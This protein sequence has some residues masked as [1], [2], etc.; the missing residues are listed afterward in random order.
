MFVLIRQDFYVLNSG[1]LQDRKAFEER[2]QSDFGA[3]LTQDL[4]AQMLLCYH[5]A[6][7]QSCHALRH[8]FRRAK[9][10]K[11]FLHEA[12]QGEAAIR[13]CFARGAHMSFT[14]GTLEGIYKQFT[15]VTSHMDWGWNF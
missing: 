10:I 13:A 2:L 7:G 5:H 1:C 12:L 11:C 3:L 9:P 14:E 8:R 6:G 15:F 4:R